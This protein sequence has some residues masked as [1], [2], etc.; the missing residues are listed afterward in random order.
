M[1]WQTAPPPTLPNVGAEEKERAAADAAG[2]EEEEEEEVVVMEA[3]M[4]RR[5][6]PLKYPTLP[7]D[8]NTLQRFVVASCS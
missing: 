4:S 6:Q 1:P 7:A 3:R 5:S 8:T 2:E